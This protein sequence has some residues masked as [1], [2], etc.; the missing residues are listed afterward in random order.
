MKTTVGRTWPCLLA[1]AL[2]IAFLMV[3][4]GCGGKSGQTHTWGF[5]NSSDFTF[6]AQLV[7]VGEGGAALAELRALPGEALWTATYADP[8]PAQAPEFHQVAFDVEGNLVVVGSNTD[9]PKRPITGQLI[10]AKYSPRGEVLP[11]WP[12]FYT[13]P[14]YR[15][16]EGEDVALDGEGNI[17]IAGYSIVDGRSWVYSVW[18]LDAGGDMLPGWPQYVASSQ[19]YGT[20]VIFDSSGEVIA[21]GASGPTGHE[22]I[23][24]ARFKRDGSMVEGWP[25]VL[26]PVAGQGA[27]SYDLM[28]DGA[29]NLVVAGYT[30]PAT[31]GRDAVLYKLDRDGKVLAGWPK[32]WD[33]GS[34]GYDEYFAVSQDAGG[35]YCVVGTGQGADEESGRLLVTRYST[36]GEQR[37]G[38]PRIYEQA[39]VRDYSPPDAWRGRVDGGGNIAAAF[40]VGTQPPQVLTLR[41]DPS[42]SIAN[43]FPKAVSR[44]GYFVGTRSCSVDDTGYVYTLGFSYQGSDEDADH[45][46]FIVKYAPGAYSP[47]RPSL[48]TR[49]GPVYRDLYGFG[50]VLG[51][52]NQGSVSYQISPDGEEWYY[53]DGSGWKVAAAEGDANTA[54]E[55]DGSIAA[56]A[57]ENGPGTL[58]IRAFLV[59]D[60]SQPVQLE[61][62]SVEYE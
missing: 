1:S 50:E 37:P 52:G 44:E 54:A 5:Q 48:T 36:E 20:G 25:K 3:I 47:G 29:G 42:G 62:M 33:S 46:A 22:N 2:L 60:G 10:V 27:F 14:V 21:C 26:Q 8:Q 12:K 59:S 41:Y 7:S 40:I 39:G 31:G 53:H 49:T 38:W 13:D 51:T 16:N 15:W 24:L 43:G 61:S 55:V 34:A 45:T 17:A 11:G 4:C 9:M 35:D 19:A 30:Q 6:D 58:Y 23:V 32:I 57:E 56:F 18:L 28:Q